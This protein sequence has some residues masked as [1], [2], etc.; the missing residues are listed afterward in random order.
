MIREARHRCFAIS[1]LLVGL[2][3]WIIPFALFIHS[4]LTH[5]VPDN[6]SDANG[7]QG[8]KNDDVWTSYF[9]GSTDDDD[10]RWKNYRDNNCSWLFGCEYQAHTAPAEPPRWWIGSDD[11]YELSTPLRAALCLVYIGSSIMF[12]GILYFG[13]QTVK[14]VRNHRFQKLDPLLPV[15]LVF[16]L[17]SLLT[18]ILISCVGGMVDTSGKEFLQYGWYGQ[19]GILLYVTAFFWIIFS[20]IFFMVIKSRVSQ[21]CSFEADSTQ[22]NYQLQQSPNRK[23][24]APGVAITP[25]RVE[26]IRRSVS[27]RR[28]TPTTSH[29]ERPQ[30]KSLQQRRWEEAVEQ[31]KLEKARIMERTVSDIV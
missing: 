13:H 6:Y 12:A 21:F 18:M 19:T 5:K 3:S 29:E 23:G 7:S 14:L 22:K 26:T 20:V 15:L 1:W 9:G 24:E 25:Q 8:N 30:L 11:S 31:K 28:I 17:F 27:P 10:I 4:R 16:G 2:A